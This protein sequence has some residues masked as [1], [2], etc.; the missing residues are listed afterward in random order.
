MTLAPFTD[1]LH[2]TMGL[3]A[4]SIGEGPIQR[5]VQERMAACGLSDPQR[6]RERLTQSAAELQ[7]LIEAVV[8]PETWFFRDPAAFGALARIARDEWRP[9]HAGAVLRLFSLPCSSGEE[10]YSMAMALLDAGLEPPQFRIH[11]VDISVRALAAARRGLYGRNSF[12]GAD[13]RFRDKYFE[14]TPQGYRLAEPV[15]ATVRFERANLFQPGFMEGQGPFDVVFCRNLLIYFDRANQDRTVALLGR[16]LA[17]GG[18]LFVGPAEAALMLEHGFAPARLP[19]AFAFR[20]AGAA[21]APP[22]RRPQRRRPGASAPRARG[23]VP[24]P[25]PARAPLSPA[26]PPRARLAE[27]AQLADQGRLPE[28]LDLCT[29]ELR[30]RGPSAPACYLMGLLQDALDQPAAAE[31]S[32]RR[33]IYLDPEHQEALL[34]LALVLRRRGDGAAARALQ[35]RARRAEQRAKG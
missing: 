29:A 2:R 3:D 24:A 20:R 4:A 30:E 33:A 12:R 18:W 9:A 13:Q 7:E 14:A 32:Y 26:P 10:P 31:A 19:R 28:A 22:V 21:A 25:E 17:D 1:L 27:A 15:R 34:H 5:A 16:L 35:E 11:A 6:Y 8:V 23:P